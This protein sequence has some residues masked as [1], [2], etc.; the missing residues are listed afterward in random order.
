M[1]LQREERLKLDSLCIR[2][3]GL[4]TETF[5]SV[6]TETKTSSSVGSVARKFFSLDSF[7]G[8]SGYAR[9]ESLDSFPSEG[10]STC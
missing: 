5:S 2:T 10:S 1:P 6:G 4:E 3:V 8:V 7:F 9:I